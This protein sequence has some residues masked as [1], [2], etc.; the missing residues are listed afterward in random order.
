MTVGQVVESNHLEESGI[1]LLQGMETQDTETHVL[2]FVDTTQCTQQ[3]VGDVTPSHPIADFM[4]W[5][6]SS[7]GNIHANPG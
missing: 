2:S 4:K 5:I 1:L 6:H 7:I 3:S